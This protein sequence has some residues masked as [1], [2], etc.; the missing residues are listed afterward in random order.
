MGFYKTCSMQFLSNVVRLVPK[1]LLFL[2]PVTILSLSIPFSVA[3][4]AKAQENTSVVCYFQ[5]DF[6]GPT[7]QWGLENG[8][9][10]YKLSG[11]WKTQGTYRF[12]TSISRNDIIESCRRS[13][14]YYKHGDKKLIDVVAANSS[15][16]RNYAI[17]ANGQE[18]KP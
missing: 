12:E 2:C 6:E 10:W 11:N 8:D 16:G 15:V 5:K 17:Y 3:S 14:R 7:W 9:G 13:Q 4:S 18:V 1:K